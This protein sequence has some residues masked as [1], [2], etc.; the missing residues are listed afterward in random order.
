[1]HRGGALSQI[2]VATTNKEISR[3]ALTATTN[4]RISRGLASECARDQHEQTMSFGYDQLICTSNGFAP[5]DGA[6]HAR[7]SGLA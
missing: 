2:N 6:R 7:G 4:E 1:M 5:M 3:R